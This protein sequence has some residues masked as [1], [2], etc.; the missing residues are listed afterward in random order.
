MGGGD[1][2]KVLKIT[3]HFQRFFRGVFGFILI[4]ISRLVR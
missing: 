3:G 1:K 2:K 4:I